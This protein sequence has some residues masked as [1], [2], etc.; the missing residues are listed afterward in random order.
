ML[1]DLN[2]W[3]RNFA[4]IFQKPNLEFLRTPRDLGSD[5]EEFYN[6]VFGHAVMILKVGDE[7]VYRGYRP[8]ITSNREFRQLR[9]QA[10]D[11]EALNPSERMDV[12]KSII[13]I[14]TEGIPAVISD[15]QQSY[16]SRHESLLGQSANTE[17]VYNDWSLDLSEICSILNHVEQDKRKE[18]YY[19]LRPDR[20]RRLHYFSDGDFVH[21]CITWIVETVNKSLS[22][23][24]LT[25]DP[26]GNA[27]QFAAT[28]R[29]VGDSR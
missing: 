7:L 12:H 8:E 29:E 22:R 10:Y 13:R 5:H 3:S 18:K 2:Q 11:S 24:F 6:Q 19:S 25:S 21:N 28:L 20:S 14:L 1:N 27:S 9:R 17:F 23:Q 4:I 26:D 16:Q 15:E